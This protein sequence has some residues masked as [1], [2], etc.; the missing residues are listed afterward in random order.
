MSLKEKKL[1]ELHESMNQIEE[2]SRLKMDSIFLEIA[3]RPKITIP[4]L[5]IKFDS[6]DTLS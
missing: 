2:Q 6:I 1:I 5:K 4:Q 3:K